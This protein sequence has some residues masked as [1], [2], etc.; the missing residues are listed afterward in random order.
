MTKER[1]CWTCY[2]ENSN[3]VVI[4]DIINDLKKKKISANKKNIL[5]RINA[6]EEVWINIDERLLT[7]ALEFA[8]ENDYIT[9]HTSRNN[10]SYRVTENAF[11]G[12]CVSCGEPITL[13]ISDDASKFNFNFIDPQVI[14]SL[15]QDVKILKEKY[16]N[17]EK[18][19]E[20]LQLKHEINI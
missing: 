10:V 20:I 7:E 2:G 6:E 11:E 12:D 17:A 14:S 13:I 9:S 1:I 4:L 8:E 3:L 19:G 16:H 5:A 15:V 18:N